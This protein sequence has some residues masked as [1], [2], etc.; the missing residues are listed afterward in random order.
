ML[1]Y[2]DTRPLILG[3][4]LV[5]TLIPLLVYRLSTGRWPRRRSTAVVFGLFTAVSLFILYG[6][7]VGYTRRVTHQMQWQ[8]DAK[9]IDA[10]APTIEGSHVILTFRDYPGYHLGI[11]SDEVADYLKRL[12]TNEV[13]VEFEVTYD[14]GKIRGFNEKRI[15]DLTS[16]RSGFGY[17]GSRGSPSRSPF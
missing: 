7:F 4:V 5:A 16:W 12:S 1:A 8:I 15:G 10:T 17:Y 3:G 6:P 2:I 11:Y 9:P 14:Y 13:P